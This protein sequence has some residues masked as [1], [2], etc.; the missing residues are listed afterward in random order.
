MSHRRQASRQLGRAVTTLPVGLLANVKLRAESSDPAIELAYL[1]HAGD[2]FLKLQY[3]LVT[4]GRATEEQLGKRFS[5][6]AAPLLALSKCADFVVNRGHYFG[7]AEFNDPRGASADETAFGTEP[8]LS[9]PDK[10]ALI[11][12]LKTF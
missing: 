11:E 3:D 2:L 4:A 6:L 5:N 10:L 12:F 7:T 1:S 8:V 9:D